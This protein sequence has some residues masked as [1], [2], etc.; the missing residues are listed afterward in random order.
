MEPPAAYGAR[1]R[2]PRPLSGDPRP[3]SSP[4]AFGPEDFPGCEPFPL[5]AA[6]L[7]DHEDRLEF[8]DGRTQTAWR[9][10]EGASV[11]HEEP[12]G[13]LPNAMRELS[14]HCGAPRSSA[15][16]RRGWCVWMGRGAGAG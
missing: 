16:A 3:S 5:P 14:R 7:D 10:S 2:R 6:A 11:E 13:M 9:V 4:P 1:K 8:W 12:V 15:W